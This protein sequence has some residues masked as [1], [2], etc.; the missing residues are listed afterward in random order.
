MYSEFSAWFIVR[1]Q[2][3][4]FY[5]NMVCNIQKQ[6]AFSCAKA[7]SMMGMPNCSAQSNGVSHLQSETSETMTPK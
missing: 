3:M 2:T 5:V 7:I 1:V 6:D 4:L